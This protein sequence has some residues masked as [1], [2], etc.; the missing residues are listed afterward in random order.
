MEMRFRPV[1]C[2]TMYGWIVLVMA[3]ESDR[4]VGLSGE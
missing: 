1:L 2:T 4:A 3:C